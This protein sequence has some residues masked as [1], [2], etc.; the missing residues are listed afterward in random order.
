M[1]GIFSLF[2][3]DLLRY[4]AGRAMPTK[5]LNATNEAVERSRIIIGPG[6][7]LE[8][9]QLVNGFALRVVQHTLFAVGRVTTTASA[10]TGATYTTDGRVTI[11]TKTSGAYADGP[12]TDVPVLNYHDKS[13]TAGATYFV[14]M[15]WDGDMW[16]IIDPSTC[17]MLGT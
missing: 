3:H 13:F 15:V 4:R 12:Q 7:G 1:R 5:R 2:G 11:Q 6:S 14:G 10:A 8:V 9:Q 17:N 16:V